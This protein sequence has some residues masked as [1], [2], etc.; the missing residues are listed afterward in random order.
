MQSLFDI[1]NVVL[2]VLNYPISLAELIGTLFGLWSVV[3]AAKARIFNYPVGIINELFFF[4]IFF[5]IQ[6]YSDMI[7]QVY[8]FI[9]S[10]YG[11]W[12]W[13]NPTIIE[14]TLN[15][16]LKITLNGQRSNF[17]MV[18]G[19][20]LGFVAMGTLVKNLH[21][22]LPQWFHLPAA[23]PYYDSLVAVGSIVAMYL[24]ARK[25]L[26]SWVLWVI[27]DGICVVLYY[28]KDIKLMSLEYLIFLM[29]A[30]YGLWSWWQEYKGYQD[31]D[32]LESSKLRLAERC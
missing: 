24:M 30:A 16:E 25:K 11:W 23:F 28:L 22:L 18:I 17:I 6:M 19:I 12:K 15:H 29:I 8:F 13:K 9:V 1:N 31:Q 2:T 7:L 27:V 5:Q 4:V 26:E 14:Q 3:L 20:A 21:I 10:L 32:V